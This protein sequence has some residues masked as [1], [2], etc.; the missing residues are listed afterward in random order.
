MNNF[1]K[2]YGRQLSF[3][4]KK[5]SVLFSKTER[6]KI[7]YSALLS[8]FINILDLFSVFLIG[9][10][11][12]LS[13]RIATR[14]SSEKSVEPTFTI[15]GK[16]FHEDKK[17]V[18]LL[19]CIAIILLISKTFFS[20]YI[21]KRLFTFLTRKSATTS[22]N[23][24][25]KILISPRE[26][27][28][29]YTSQEKLY[30]V[31]QGVE[32]IFI[33]TIATSIVLVADITLLLALFFGLVLIDWI[34]ALS[35]LFFFGMI[36]SILY[37]YLH[38]K[39]GK[40]GAESARLN[41]KSNYEILG[42]FESLREI[43]VSNK[44]AFFANKLEITR[45]ELSKNLAIL[46]FLPYISKYA[47]EIGLVLGTV[48]VATIQFFRLNLSEAVSTSILFMVAGTRIAP[49]LLRIQQSLIQ[50]RIS[51]GKS[52]ETFSLIEMLA[53]KEKINLEKLNFDLVNQK[54]FEPKIALRDVFF[55]YR[56]AQ[57]DTLSDISLEIESGQFIAIVGPSGSGK[58]T[59]IDL[60]LGILLPKSGIVSISGLPPY[61]A[62]KKFPGKVSYMPQNIYIAEGSIRDNI[63]YGYSKE[64][65]SEKDIERCVSL[66]NLGEFVGNLPNGLDTKV[67]EN[68]QSL[69]GGQKQR[70][71]LARALFSEPK[72]LIL[73]EATSALDSD[74][75][76]KV[77]NTLNQLKGE[78]TMVVVAHRLSTIQ[79]ADKIIYVESGKVKEVGTFESISERMPN[80]TK[81]LKSFGL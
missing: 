47:F 33:G 72:I 19:M 78:T 35:T 36:F 55:S 46:N 37:N 21:T 57:K 26:E 10:L 14:I 50:I 5:F 2:I 9:I 23:L 66:A 54:D 71:G 29:K 31:T 32:N 16:N 68:G 13:V 52:M 11:G 49:A 62:F 48:F 70:I 73:D 53:K 63:A 34:L 3:T 15:L 43:T 24:I 42:V 58:S 12:A 45:I 27:V 6:R 18:I 30:A 60:M 22:S 81:T 56:G 74:S 4:I 8:S 20:M 77:I 65:I 67:S 7:K 51:W 28:N 38:V 64:E 75:E 39:S 80:F 41:V 40:L 17:L 59:L 1:A 61:E 69:S 25:Q 79:E 76:L 44:V